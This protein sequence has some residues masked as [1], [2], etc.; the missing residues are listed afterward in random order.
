MDYILIAEPN[1]Q[2]GQNWYL[3]DNKKAAI[4]NSKH[5]H[6][7]SLGRSEAGFRWISIAGARIYSCYWS[8]NTAVADFFDFL[9]RL[10]RSIRSAKEDIL[11]A[12]DFNAKHTDWGCPKNDR[13][14]EALADLISAAG[15]VICNKGKSCTFNKGTILDLTFATPRIA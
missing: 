15:L 4:V 10:E 6:I 9:L 1:R 11:L 3:D 13:R 14:G 12:G 8:P 2:D 5:A 7:T